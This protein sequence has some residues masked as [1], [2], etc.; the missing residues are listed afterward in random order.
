MITAR[1]DTAEF[2]R[3]IGQYVSLKNRDMADVLKNVAGDL[4]LRSAQAAKAGRKAS[5]S[6]IQNLWQE[7][8]WKSKR[9]WQWGRDW[10]GLFLSKLLASEGFR[11]RLGRSKAK[12]AERNVSWYDTVNRK[13]R[14]GRKSKTDFR[15]V[16]RSSMKASDW[17]RVSRRILARRAGRVGGFVGAFAQVA[18]KF[19]KGNFGGKRAWKAEVHVPTPSALFASFTVGI[20]SGKYPYRGDKR[21]PATTDAAKKEMILY[22]YMNQGMR[23][24]LHDP[25]SGLVPYIKRKLVERANRLGLRAA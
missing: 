12:G 7:T 15:Q 9:P 17:K 8:D 6:E 25:R 4:A 20:N 2:S 13:V 21:T 22:G 19:G 5:K 11:L 23:S 3:V 14:F 16:S 24:V 18:V 10:W 1:L